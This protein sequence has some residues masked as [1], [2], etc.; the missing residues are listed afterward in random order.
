MSDFLVITSDEKRILIKKE[1][2]LGVFEPITAK[3]KCAISVAEIG[4]FECEETFDEV[5]GLIES[6]LNPSD[7][8]RKTKKKDVLTIAPKK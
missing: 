3:G 4:S 2:I 7:M 6:E 5:L 8:G 1:W